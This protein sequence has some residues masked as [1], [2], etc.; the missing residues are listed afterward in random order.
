M[1]GRT[2][3]GR[4]VLASTVTQTKRGKATT[5]TYPS[6]INLSNYNPDADELELLGMGLTY[7]PTPHTGRF[8]EEELVADFETL[9]TTHMARYCGGLPTTS[10]RI[11]TTVCD[12]IVT[13]LRDLQ[14]KRTVPN[15]PVRLTR[16]LRKLRSCRDIVISQADKGD[17][18][19]ILDTSRYTSM[20]WQHLADGET[21]SLL[22]ED[23][24]PAIVEKFNNYLRRCRDDRVIDPGLHDRLKLDDNTAAQTIYFLPKVHKVPLKLRPIVSCSG[25][26]TAG[27]SHY[28][29]SLLQTHARAAGSYVENSIEVVNHLRDLR[30]PR[31]AL[32]VSLD[33]ESLYTNISHR[34][35]IIAFSRRF[36]DHPKFVLLLDLLKFVL[37]NNVFQF[38]GRFFRQTCGI[39]MGTPLA[40]ALATIVIADLEERYLL[41]STLTP[42]TWLRY[43]DDI[44]A[45]WTHG[46]DALQ[47]FI[48]GLNRR[49]ARI[50]FTWQSSFVSA[51][52]LDLRIYKPADIAYTERLATSIYYKLTNTF[53]YALG[54]SYI[55]RHTLRGIAIGETVRA[56]RNCDTRKKFELA[57]SQLL[58]H[59]RR[60]RYPLSALRAVKG[61][62]FSERPLYL[63]KRQG[64]RIERPLPL[65]TLYYPF[66][67]PLGTILRQAWDRVYRD[68]FLS[69]ALPTP[70]FPAFKNH[71]T[72]GALFSHKRK[73]FDSVPEQ[74]TLH[75]ERGIPFAHLRFNRPR[76]KQDLNKLQMPKMLRSADRSCSNKKCLACPLLLHPNYVASKTRDTTHP[77]THNLRCTTM[78]VVYLLT[79]R[80]CGKQY[81]GQ[82]AKSIRERLARHRA[83]FRVA[84]M[85]LYSHFIRY[86]HCDTL[87]V[88]IVLLCQESD[89][90][91][92]L[93]KEQQWIKQLG[94]VIPAGLNNAT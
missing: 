32:L 87:D 79:C 17:A 13:Q 57:R 77:V 28:L 15:L 5:N 35:A 39:A 21:Y 65:N 41:E 50:H 81:V 7:I 48:D 4:P 58:L 88:S 72:L 90:E 55:A 40:P 51:V 53:S 56:L 82:T 30:V 12:N 24:T 2:G 38:D 36:K 60:R 26:P 75:R 63:E 85:S 34:S 73:R 70:P 76:R 52:F 27:A 22:T 6:V 91:L 3:P 67:R 31:D 69:Q 25:G 20:A 8:S 18:T 64:K 66:N 74:P 43:I 14:P 83:S 11:K 16:A 71:P 68:P 10:D 49:E 29:N 61:I 45:V 54:N 19:V 1:V 42:T 37:G 92:R 44:F 80:R 86:H 23:P 62:D 78:G 89:S 94:T 9:R 46:R 33:I 47:S 84:P 59:F 93:R